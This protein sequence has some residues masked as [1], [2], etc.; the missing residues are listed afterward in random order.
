M[1]ALA[2]VPSAGLADLVV[3]VEEE[4]VEL[5]HTI[6]TV[7]SAV[8]LQEPLRRLTL[9]RPSHR[10]TQQHV[11]LDVLAEEGQAGWSH[12]EA[13]LVAHFGLKLLEEGGGKRGG[14]GVACEAKGRERGGG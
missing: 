4:C 12:P 5:A 11:V 9:P 13:L 2:A 7:H 10:L 6:L 14:E 1:E 3:F 8:L